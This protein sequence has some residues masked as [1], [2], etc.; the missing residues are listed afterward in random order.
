MRT[1]QVGDVVAIDLL[2]GESI[3]VNSTEPEVFV[4]T[5]DFDYE[6]TTSEIK[7]MYT[8]EG[9]ISK[10]DLY[11]PRLENGSNKVLL[12]K[13]GT[14]PVNQVARVFYF[15]ENVK[16]DDLGRGESWDYE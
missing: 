15:T 4:E 12:V 3:H 11:V 10:Y 5:G 7:E 14:V 6:A 9:F 8:P 2:S 13:Y 16:F 1:Y